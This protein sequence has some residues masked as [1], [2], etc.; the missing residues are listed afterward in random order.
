MTVT[1]DTNEIYKETDDNVK[2]TVWGNRSPSS[3]LHKL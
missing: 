1:L 2:L 3:F